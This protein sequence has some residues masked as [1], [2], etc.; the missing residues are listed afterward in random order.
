MVTSVINALGATLA[1]VEDAPLKI[2]GINMS[3][4]FEPVYAI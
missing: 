4:M 2:T 3:E 1:N